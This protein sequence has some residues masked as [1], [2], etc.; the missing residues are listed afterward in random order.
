MSN[1]NKEYK[2]EITNKIIEALKKGSAPWQRP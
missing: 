1:M 2:L